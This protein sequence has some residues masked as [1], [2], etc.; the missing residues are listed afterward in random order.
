[1]INFLMSVGVRINNFFD[2]TIQSKVAELASA[3]PLLNTK[4]LA[5]KKI[6][7]KKKLHW[8]A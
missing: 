4:I 2:Q 7:I 3:C 1:M 6:T 5:R 8:V